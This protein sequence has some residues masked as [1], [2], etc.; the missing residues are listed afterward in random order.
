MRNNSFVDGEFWR[1]VRQ[2]ANFMFPEEAIRR[3]DV[4]Q[5]G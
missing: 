4:A 2:L 1:I 5:S 3:G